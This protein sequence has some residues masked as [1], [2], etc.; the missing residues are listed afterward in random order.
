[1]ITQFQAIAVARE[2]AVEHIGPRSQVGAAIEIVD[3]AVVL[4]WSRPGR[5]FLKVVF[6]IPESWDELA[7]RVAAAILS[8][9]RVARLEAYTRE[10]L[11]QIEPLAVSRTRPA[12]T[13]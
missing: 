9:K 6:E 4:F 13:N 2:A 8:L 7:R 5:P 11:K 10:I 1:M 3:K 12:T